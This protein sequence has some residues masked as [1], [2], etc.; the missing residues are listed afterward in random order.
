[1]CL[2]VIVYVDDLLI[3][4]NDEDE[5]V[6]FK[7]Y[8]SHCFHMKD[9][10]PLKYFLGIEVARSSRGI[11]LSQRKYA[12]DII[13]ECGLL[14]GR[15]V[16]TPMLQNHKLEE[17]T[18]GILTRR[19][20]IG[21]WLGDWLKH[22]WAALRVV[23]YL[24][25]SPGQGILFTANG[26]LHISAYCDSDF[27]TCPISRRSLSGYVVLLG[28]SPIAWKTKKQGVVSQSS[29]EAEYRAMS[30]TT[31]ELKWPFGVLL[32]DSIRLHCD[33]QA[34]LH[35]AA[36]P[37]FHERTKHIE[38]DCHYIRDEIQNGLIKTVYVQTTQQLA[39]IFTKAL[40]S[41]AFEY[42]SRK[43]GI[44]DLHAPT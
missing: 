8:L 36:N 20:G 26:D 33:N 18:G 11:Y 41:P 38:R 24:K 37:V 13:N 32:T 5:V 12:L 29:A 27:S 21:V 42:L 7:Q 16:C 39:D 10:G 14:G 31:S 35:I 25:N 6:R 28:G 9:L 1:M 19:N 44:C 40:G 22:W 43:L 34:A 2:Y 15:P 3:G 30:F 17:D 4:G 23:R